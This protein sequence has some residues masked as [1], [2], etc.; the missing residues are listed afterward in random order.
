MR[1]RSC[2]P[3]RSWL[4]CPA[5]LLAACGGSPADEAIVRFDTIGSVVH[6]TNEGPG[7]WADGRGLRIGE[8]RLRLGRM[9]GEGPDLFGRVAA[10]AVGPE[11]RVYVAD[12]QARDVR[13]FSPGGSF[14]FSFGR[15]GEGP[16]EF[17]EIDGLAVGPEG[18]VSVRDPRL[19]RVSRFSGEGE[20]LD[21]FRLERAY[22]LFS[23]GTTLWT[24]R[25]GR[26]FDRIQLDLRIG[27]PD[28]IAMLV[29]EAGGG[30]PDTVPL[31]AHRIPRITARRG[32]TTVGAM[33]APFAAQ[34]VASV[35]PGGRIGWAAGDVY[36]VA[37]LDTGG[38]S[39]R[40][41]GRTLEPE[42]VPASARRAAL[43]GLERRAE[44]MFGEARLEEPEL[45]T[46]LPFLTRLVAD[47]LGYWWA[48]RYR[49]A[50]R[51]PDDPTAH[52]PVAWDV[53][54]PEGRFLGSVASPPLRVFQIGVDFVAGVE[55]DEI[56]VERVV[57]L[58]L[59]GGR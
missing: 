34:V 51:R 22:L 3:W 59:D 39:L 48:G 10:L 21:S 54:D 38:D 41:F 2:H 53:F 29:Y 11:G 46:R 8:P 5:T 1:L 7:A 57:V 15:Q 32:E 35:G 42:P 49:G 18:E 47:A 23:D 30:V 6:A 58:E 36:R 25:Q 40:T 52:L 50:E 9:E 26:L 20:F 55:I 28:Q 4:A 44:E 45:P 37:V 27:E 13:A 14:L 56:G 31:V 43:D 12:G 16:G 24:D 33:T 17:E 19:G